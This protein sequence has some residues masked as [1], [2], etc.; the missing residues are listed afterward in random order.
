MIKISSYSGVTVLETEHTLQAEIT[1]VW[2]FFSSPHNLGRITPP[3]MNFRITG[4]DADKKS[5]PGQIITYS[6][7]PFLGIKVNW[8]TEIT[9]LIDYSTFTDEQRS[10]PFKFWHHRHNF[11]TEGDKVIM[12]DI[13]TFK[14]FGGIAGRLI[15]RLIV[16][17]RLMAIFRYRASVINEIFGS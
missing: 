5:Y 7:C 8:V 16:E 9:H 10:G 11:R 12:N 1:K 4:T 15:G 2:D 17:P 3:W 14:V 13:L 6:V